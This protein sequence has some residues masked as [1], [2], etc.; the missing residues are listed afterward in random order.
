MVQ[1][2]QRSDRALRKIATKRTADGE[3]PVHSLATLL[4]D[5]ATI[6]KNRIRPAVGLP[7]FDKITRPTSLQQRAFDL[8]GL[9]SPL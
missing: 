4:E 6:V 7:E 8:L 1:K 5:L 9:K 2:A 3:F